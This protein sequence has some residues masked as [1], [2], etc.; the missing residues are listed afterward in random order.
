MKEKKLDALIQLVCSDPPA[1]ELTQEQDDYLGWLCNDDESQ[2][3]YVLHAIELQRFFVPTE[4]AGSISAS[5][6]DELRETS[7]KCYELGR[8]L[9]S[10]WLKLSKTL[11]LL[12]EF[13]GLRAEAAD[14]RSKRSSKRLPQAKIAELL[15]DLIDDGYLEINLN[16][17]PKSDLAKL[18][19][20]CCEI[21]GI[22]A[23][24]NAAYHLKPHI[25]RSGKGEYGL[26][27]LSPEE[28]KEREICSMLNIRWPPYLDDS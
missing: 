24:K 25:E 21:A 17:D 6:R 10:H 27:V 26:R 8:R 4:K 13:Y 11:G 14:P 18:F 28:E 12:G 3:K 1:V 16:Q 7:E 20:L 22:K 19:R 23:S 2:K 9:E 15:V 5:N